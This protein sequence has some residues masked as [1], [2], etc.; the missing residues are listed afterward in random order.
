MTMCENAVRKLKKEK[1]EEEEK[2]LFP[3]VPMSITT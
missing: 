3:E 2:A 1:G